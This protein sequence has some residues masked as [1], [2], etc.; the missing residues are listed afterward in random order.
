MGFPRINGIIIGRFIKYHLISP[1]TSCCS[2]SYLNSSSLF[3]LKSL[4]NTWKGW[5]PRRSLPGVRFLPLCGWRALKTLSL[6]SGT[7][8]G[9]DPR[10]GTL[11]WSRT[12]PIVSRLRLWTVIRQ[13]PFLTGARR[14]KHSTW[15][16]DVMN[17][18]QRK[19][20]TISRSPFLSMS[21]ALLP[22]LF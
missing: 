21:L 15:L 3:N 9:W 1:N 8:V 18:K 13:S 20:S 22:L 11:L 2:G 14:C 12:T 17:E 16:F 7:S 6:W 4:E 19:T 10:L 5:Q